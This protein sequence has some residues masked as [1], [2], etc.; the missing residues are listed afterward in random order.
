MLC[1]L[2]NVL[3]LQSYVLIPRPLCLNKVE[4]LFSKKN[5]LTIDTPTFKIVA[6]TPSKL[7]FILANLV[8]KLKY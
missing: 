7:T 5:V 1:I 8:H 3:Y 4:S 2:Q 6:L